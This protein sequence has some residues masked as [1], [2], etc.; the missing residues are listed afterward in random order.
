MK[1]NINIAVRSLVTLSLLFVKISSQ[2]SEQYA[3]RIVGQAVDVRGHPVPFARLLITSAP[4]DRGGDFD[5]TSRANADGHF[6][7]AIR[8]SSL[9]TASRNLYITGPLPRNSV[10]LAEPPF[11]D[12]KAR[13]GAYK[14][15]IKRDG[16]EDIGPLRVS[17]LYAL[18]EI[19]LKS[20]RLTALFRDEHAWSTVWIRIVDHKGKVGG[21]GTLSLNNIAEAVDIPEGVIRVAVPTGSWV[22]EFS[23]H[24]NRG[25]WSRLG[26][27]QVDGGQA[28]PRLLSFIAKEQKR[29]VKRPVG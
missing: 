3:Y 25:P 26:R 23:S 14:L 29:A 11:D 20:D 5:Y 28:T 7:L 16:T 4:G 6:D 12:V 1:R 18:V 21:V 9:L 15:H 10:P 24:E 8:E 2:S 22:V 13:A 27:V 19:R 17:V